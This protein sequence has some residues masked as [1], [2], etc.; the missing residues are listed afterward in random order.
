MINVDDRLIKEELPHIGTD[1]FTILCFISSHLGKKN[2]AWPG[3]DRIREFCTTLSSSGEPKEMARKRAYNSIQK[4]IERGLIERSQHNASGEFGKVVYTVTTKYISVYATANQFKL[5]EPCGQKRPSGEEPCGQFASSGKRPH[6]SINNNRSI[7]K[8]RDAREE[9]Q[10][11]KPEQKT[12]EPK[13][14]KKIETDWVP[15]AN[16]I[17]KDQVAVDQIKSQSDYTGKIREFTKEYF[18]NLVHK[19]YFFQLM[20]PEGPGEKHRWKAKHIAGISRWIM[21]D[22]KFYPKRNEPKA[23]YSA[24]YHTNTFDYSL[25]EN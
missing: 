3:M 23:E 12:D 9:N 20:I 15:A 11:L 4:L 17:L 22:R 19:G 25:L 14:P 6:L 2:K 16:Q 1:A 10:E 21:N 5:E 24:P 7:N 13:Q 8:E 18:L